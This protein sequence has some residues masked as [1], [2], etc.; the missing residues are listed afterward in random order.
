MSNIIE[1][2]TLEYIRRIDDM[3]GAIAALERGF[4]ARE[5]HE[6][7]FKHQKEVEAGSRVVVGVNKYV[8]KEEITFQ[9]TITDKTST[10]RQID[11]LVRVRKQRNNTIIKKHLARLEEVARTNENVMP[12]IIDAVEDYCTLGE[13]SNVFRAVFGQYKDQSGISGI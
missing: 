5:I 8:T 10:A 13:I 3:G 2:K 9:S 12:V 11:R 1:K 4:Q 6:A 7:A